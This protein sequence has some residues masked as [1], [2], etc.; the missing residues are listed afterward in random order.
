MHLFRYSGACAYAWV[1]VYT[2]LYLP[3]PILW[4]QASYSL[5]AIFLPPD[6]SAL[7]RSYYRAVMNIRCTAKRNN[8][9]SDGC[10]NTLHKYNLEYIDYACCKMA[11]E[12]IM[13]WPIRDRIERNTHWEVNRFTS[14]WGTLLIRGAICA[15]KSGYYAAY[16][17]I[18]KP[19]WRSGFTGQKM[20]LL[21]V[22]ISGLPGI[23][24]LRATAF[25]MLW[26][27]CIII[28]N[29]H[30]QEER[31]TKPGAWAV[32][33]QP[34]SLCLMGW[35]CENYVREEFSLSFTWVFLALNAS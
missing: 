11:S 12:S 8:I 17:W 30:Y 29:T 20:N 26:P 32:L 23:N 35:F 19:Q 1:M 24:S 2:L 13:I 16:N 25:R 27:V 31:N 15:L 7:T 5:R 34:A 18:P 4:Q 14:I 10:L 9:M 3:F 33:R 28:R 6:Q 22:F 21:P